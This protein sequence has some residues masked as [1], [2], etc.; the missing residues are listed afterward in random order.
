M[1]MKAFLQ[2]SL[3]GPDDITRTVLPNGINVLAR[4]NFNSPS[5][6]IGGYLPCGSLFD[7]DDKLGLAD[8]TAS[9]L[10]RGSEKRDFQKTFDDLESAGAT[11][12]IPRG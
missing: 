12:E 4:T 8:F 10:L 6:V 7:T 2:H 11:L 1:S 3:P 5:V 9:G